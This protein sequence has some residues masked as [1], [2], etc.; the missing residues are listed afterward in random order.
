[1]TTVLLIRHGLTDYVT[2]GRCAGR[3]PGVSLNA[4]GQ[5]QALAVAQRVKNLPIKAIYSSPMERTQE[6]AQAIAAATG[7]PVQLRPGLLET[8][9]GDW[10]GQTFSE[11][12]AQN[13]AIWQAIQAH[14]KGTR[15][16]GGETMDEIQARM[17]AAIDAICREHPDGMV[18]VVSHADPIK[19]AIAHYIGLDLNQFQKLVINPT[20]VSVIAVNEHGAALLVM[21]HNGDLSDLTSKQ[22]QR[23]AVR[24][25]TWPQEGQTMPRIVYDLKPLARITAS[26]VGM[27]GQR[28]FYLQARDSERL[29]TLV[30]EKDHV[31]AL[32]LGIDELLEELDK[33]QPGSASDEPVAAIDLELEEPLEPVFRVGQLGLGYDQ[34]ANAIVLVAYELPESAETDPESLSAARLWATPS[35]ARALS[36]HAAAVVQS[37]R[38]QCHLCGEPMDPAGHICPKK[39]GHKKIEPA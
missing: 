18:A 19:A 33:Q 6:T 14:P 35:Q 2:G 1:M 5:A 31:A 23:P 36:K 15:I 12:Q 28:T 7:L 9:T 8:D 10:T 3:T 17:A 26:A 34:D 24:R 22:H 32:A 16:P 37:G 21:N 20:S 27:P 4:A 29:F 38:P 39:N 30:C 11:I 13:A 25:I